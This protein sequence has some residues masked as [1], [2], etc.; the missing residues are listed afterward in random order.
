MRI[1]HLLIILLACQVGA[2]AQSTPLWLRYPAIS[3]DGKEIVFGYKGDLFKVGINGGVASPLT[4]HEAHNAMPVWSPDGKHIAFAS[5]RYG[6]FDVYIIPS[7]GGEARRLTFHSGNDFPWDFTPDGKQV[8]FSSPR[9]DLY[10]SVRFP[11]KGLFGKLY[12]VPVE[13]G[14]NVLIST[15]GMQNASFDGSGDRIIFQDRKGYE[16]EWRKRHTSSVTRDIWV[17]DKK[18]QS[19]TQLSDFEGED[20]EPVFSKDG[21]SIFYLSEKNGSQNLY[22]KNISTG[23][24]I[25]LTDFEDHPVRHLSSSNEDLF[26]FSWNGEIYTLQEG[27]KPKKLS[28]EIFGD[29]RGNEQKIVSVNSGATEMALSPNGKEVAFVFRGEVFVT[30]VENNQTKRITNS[31]AQERM[32]SWGEDGRTLYY[33]TERGESWDIY[34]ASITRSEEPYFFAA[35]LI[36]E[37]PI[38]ATDKD[39]F[40]PLVSPDGKELAYLE[41]RNVLKVFNLADKTSRTIIPA[42]ENFSYADGDQDFT[43]SPDSKWLVAKNALGLYGA[44]HMVLYDAKGQKEG[45]NLTNSGFSDGRGRF[46][47]NGKALIWTNDRDGK[48]PLAMQGA[49]ELDVYALFFDQS[50]FDQFKL[51]KADY[52]LLKDKEKKNKEDKKT[53]DNGSE[54]PLNLNLEGLENRKLRLT[55]GSLNL[56]SFDLSPDGD[57]LYMMASFENKYDIWVFDTRT[58]ELKSLAKTN[59]GPGRV[60]LDK[61]GKNLFVLANGKLSKIETG[62]GKLSNIGINEEMVLDAT[63]ERDYIFHHT[64]RQVKKKF[65]DPELHGIDWDMYR[66]NYA[67]FL[68]HIN[69]N[70]DFQELLSEILG[71]LNGSHTGGRYSHR[72]ENGDQTASLGLFFDER[73]EESGLKVMEVITGGPLDKAESKIKAG[74]VIEKID[75]VELDENLDWNKTLNRKAGKNVLLSL[76]DPKNNSRW[77][78]S[79][80]PISQ[81]A[82]NQLL[83]KRWVETMRAMV[84]SLSDGRIG[85]VHVQGMNDNSFRTVYDEVLGKNAD[86]E[87]LIVDTRFNGGGWL[88]EDLST[89]LD[90]KPYATFRPYGFVTRGGEPR[91]KWSKPS[92]V[93]MSESNYSDAHAFPYA[94]RA[95]GIGKLIGMPVPGTSTAVWWETQIDPTI[96][97]G[98]P[99]I[100]FYGI[101]ED[102]PLE[103]L[104][105]EPDIKVSTPFEEVLYGKDAQIE[106]AVQELIDQIK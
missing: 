73:S 24:E 93:V 26:T 95:K 25:Q 39:E 79:V 45:V 83:Y 22:K 74:H 11:N 8:I 52:D 72:S 48:K 33:S 86:K 67:R 102:R 55:T 56:S 61:E 41:E 58:K 46:A 76:F 80:K 60:Q 94:Y 34:R 77:E 103:N 1:I 9:N 3:P 15:A 59:S 70:Y 91:D 68:P 12:A 101:E 105:L 20:R 71:E 16:D 98:I 75:G 82:E 44:S 106:A 50:A 6:N 49:R 84:D 104:Q 85:Y 53:D 21:N 17:F 7:S 38:M 4:L 18:N 30:S 81:G 87:A 54:E 28:I 13:G 78:E 88:H 42:G 37:E 96:V 36:K 63:A 43:W 10:T 89:F 31:P 40:Q 66:D 27:E 92:V 32:L 57:K 99:M 47:M 29:F 62:S 5:D 2:I 65:Y 23:D 19:Y 64:W 14:R 35:T 51:S 69:N 97:F 100:A 90:G